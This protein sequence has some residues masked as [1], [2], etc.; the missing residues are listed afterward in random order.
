MVLRVLQLA[1][2]NTMD[3]VGWQR[4]IYGPQADQKGEKNGPLKTLRQYCDCLFTLLCISGYDNIGDEAQFDILMGIFRHPLIERLVCSSC[5]PII[6]GI[7]KCYLDKLN[8]LLH[9]K[10]KEV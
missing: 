1:K 4:V 3:C 7:T 8:N 10:T 6:H 9:H 2:H 5:T